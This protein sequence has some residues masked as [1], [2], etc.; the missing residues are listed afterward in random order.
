MLAYTYVQ[1]FYTDWVYTMYPISGQI[2]A[3]NSYTIV[4]QVNYIREPLLYNKMSKILVKS[5]ICFMNSG[6]SQRSQNKFE[7]ELKCLL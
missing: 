4:V 7:N 1:A 6:M 5:N 3:S 2:A